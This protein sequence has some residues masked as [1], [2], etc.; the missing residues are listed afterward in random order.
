MFGWPC[1]RVLGPF[2]I[3]LISLAGWAN[4]RQLHVIDYLR[5]EKRVLRE[6][7]P[8]RGCGSTMISVFA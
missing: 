4:Q 2:R 6:Q 1:Q 8:T 5:K 7:Q 3:V